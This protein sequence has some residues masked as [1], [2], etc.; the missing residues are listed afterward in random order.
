MSRGGLTLKLGKYILFAGSLIVTLTAMSVN[1]DTV[2]DQSNAISVET[3]DNSMIS[4]DKINKEN[5]NNSQS[6]KENENNSQS[7]SQVMSDLTKSSSVQSTNSNDLNNNSKPEIKKIEEPAVSEKKTTVIN[8]PKAN[9]VEV[10]NGWYSVQND[11]YYYKNNSMQKG[12]LHGGND[13]YYFDP[14]NGRMHKKW[15]QG[16]NDWYYFNS[17]NG[18]MQKKWLQGGNDWYYF[19]PTSGHMKT[20]WLQGGNDWYY[21]NPQSGH[22]QRNWLQGGNDWYYFNP[23]N[24]HMW[25]KWLQGGN[26]WYYLDSVNGHMQKGWLQGINTWYYFNYYNGKMYSNTFFNDGGQTYFAALSGNVHSPKYVSQWIPVRAPEGCTIASIAMLM[27]IKGERITNMYAA[28]ANLPQSG[29]VFTG[30]GF[31]TIIPAS[32]LVTYVRRYSSDIVN[33]SG[34]SI[35]TL[36]NY[37]QNGHPV[38]YYGWSG[39]ERTYWNR[40]HAKVIVGYRNGNFHVYDPC[41]NHQLDPA[42]TSGGGKYDRGADRWISWGDLASEYNGSGAV[43]IV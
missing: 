7:T 20:N 8:E 29:N 30:A 9:A 12:W 14:Q 35:S 39:Y 1:A 5:E 25:K 36:V 42:G 24:G 28:Y 38:L 3:T 27:S 15:L 2:K 17:I 43:T 21:F 37:I 34:S 4:K 31:T 11:W 18:R 40:N 6:N 22:M 23:T 33:I 16:G 13:W 41:Y 19:N 10:K 26:D 32:N